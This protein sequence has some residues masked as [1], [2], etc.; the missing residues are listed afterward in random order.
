MTR[1]ASLILAAAV[2]GCAPTVAGAVEGSSAAGPIGGTDIRSAQVL[3]PGLYGGAVFFYAEAN[4]YLDGHGNVVLPDLELTRKRVGPFLLWV[5]DLDVA[6]GRLVLAGIAP[7]GQE[8]GRLVIVTPKRC[9]S[10]AADP[11]VEFTWTR[12]FG[13]P[14]KSRWPDAFPVAE[15]LTIAFGFG[16]VIPVG[17][18]NV[19]DATVQGL[20]LGN[21]IWDFAPVAAFT[22]IG[23]PIIADGTE[24]SAKM[25]WNNYLTNPA[26]Q[27]HTGSL[28]N[29]DFAVSEKIGRFQVGLAGFLAWQIEDD[30][31][32]G[33]RIE[34]DGRR[35]EVLMLGPVL[36]YDIPEVP[37]V[38]KL[39]VLTSVMHANTVPNRGVALTVARRLSP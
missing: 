19:F 6:G 36:A 39:K 24:I 20:T 4:K 23:P 14:R 27:Y 26:T 32:N 25:Y 7:V 35:G 38:V 13:T 33:V 28:L 11:Y 10:G 37:A 22:Y 31:I 17:T 15:G 18:Y 16:V 12:Y 9:I 1:I 5:P 29:I 34:P 2:L 8:C 3:P 30:R 21:N